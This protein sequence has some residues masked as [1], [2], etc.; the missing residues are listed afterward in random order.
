MIKGLIIAI[1]TAVVM[2]SVQTGVVLGETGSSSAL[3]R[4]IVDKAA[5][6]QSTAIPASD[7]KEGALDAPTGS[8]A[9]ATDQ[10]PIPLYLENARSGLLVWC[11]ISCACTLLAAIAWL[12][13]ANQ[14][15]RTATGQQGVTRSGPVWFFALLGLMVMLAVASFVEL[16]FGGLGALLNPDIIVTDCAMIFALGIVG[17]Y[18]STVIGT[19]SM[20]RA[21]IPMAHL[22]YR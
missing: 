8:G 5:N 18:T 6:A 11:A 21:A 19:P 13:K 12:A 4:T 2:F 16:Q 22:M 15:N 17:Y 14:V 20:V 10:D 1:A 7:S 3:N 9:G